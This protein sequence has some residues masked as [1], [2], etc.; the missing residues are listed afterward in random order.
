M[1]APTQVILEFV[2][3]FVTAWPAGNAGRVAAFFAEDASYHNGPLPPVNG[4]AAIQATLAEFMAMG[5]EVT[6]DMLNL[7]A[8][9][10][11]VMTER[12]DHF[13]VADKTYSL[14]V[15]GVFEVVNDK[16]A[17]WRDYF[18]LGQFSSMLDTSN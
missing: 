12:V 13:V 2:D 7:L 4:R 18:D 11:I 9:E 3:T 6:V 16:I 14:P 8:D 17:A 15:M 1:T 10:R 5:G